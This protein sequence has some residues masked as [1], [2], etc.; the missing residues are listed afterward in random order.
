MIKLGV[1]ILPDK[2]LKLKIIRYKKLIKKNFG[3]QRYLS[4]LPHCTLCVLNVTKN[5]IKNIK[6]DKLIIRKFKQYLKIINYDIFYD[7]PITNGNTIIFKIEK[8]KFLK[9]LQLTILKNLQKCNFKTKKNYKIRKMEK[10]FTKYGY[11]FV[12]INW[13]PHYTIAS[14]SKKIKEKNFLKLLKNFKNKNISQKVNKV[15]FYQIKKNR[16]KLICIKK[17]YQRAL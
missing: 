7:D 11:P 9:E 17:I 14:L 4:H 15:Y 3:E 12:N 10:N 13:K 6:T 5:S 1:F 16:H 8:N 2:S